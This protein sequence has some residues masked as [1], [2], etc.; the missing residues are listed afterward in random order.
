MSNDNMPPSLINFTKSF[1]EK[2]QS[3]L[4]WPYR[5]E[6]ALLTHFCPCINASD[7]FALEFYAK[8]QITTAYC[9]TTKYEQSDW[10]KGGQYFTVLH[11]Y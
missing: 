1:D 10:S 4:E 7:R 5:S 6:L 8:M 2:L 3:C 11:G 9:M